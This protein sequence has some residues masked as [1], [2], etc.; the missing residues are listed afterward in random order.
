MIF[1]SCPACSTTGQFA[2]EGEKW[3][4][5]FVICSGCGTLY[6]KQYPEQQQDY[7]DYGYSQNT[8]PEFIDRRCDELVKPFEAY[9]S[10]NR[11]LEVGFGAGTIISAA[12]RAGWTVT[13]VEVSK[14]AVRALGN[15]HPEFDLRCGMLEE[16]ELPDRH[17]DAVA[18]VEVIEHVIDP[19]PVLVEVARIL[20]PGGVAWVTTPSLGSLTWKL[21]GLDWSMVAPPDHLE[22]FSLDGIKRLA[23]RSG[24]KVKKIQTYGLNPVEI[25]RYYQSGRKEVTVTERLTSGYELNEALEDSKL[26]KF[27]KIAVNEI[28]NIT[29][30]GDGAKLWAE[31][32]HGRNM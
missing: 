15:Q 11:F 12:A 8:I 4:Y 31:K 9:R 25:V 30:L 7:D 26:K 17:F 23:E 14:A 3:N 22:I 6:T 18:I 27:A 28:L 13:G 2:D 19:L 20:R 5:S 1:R 16:Q 32:P 24:L 10:T 21:L 29:G